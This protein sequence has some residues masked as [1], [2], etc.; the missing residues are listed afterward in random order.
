[1]IKVDSSFYENGFIMDGKG[2]RVFLKTKDGK[3]NTEMIFV[4][5]TVTIHKIGSGI[6]S[7]V[8]FKKNIEIYSDAHYG[9]LK[10]E[11][12]IG[13]DIER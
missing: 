10:V 7:F 1:M 11:P 13:I 5:D 6:E 12:Y 9:Q 3:V 2:N 4:K 8:D